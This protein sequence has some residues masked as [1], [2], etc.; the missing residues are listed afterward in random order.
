[1]TENAASPPVLLLHGWG[2]TG[3]RAWGA[4]PLRRRLLDAG[5]EVILIDLPGHGD[6]GGPTRPDGYA[7]L[8]GLT[9]ARIPAGRIDA[10]GFSLGGK[11]L[12]WLDA[13]HPGRF[14]RLV[15]GG[16]GDNILRPENGVMIADALAAGGVGYP[17]FVAEVVAEALASGNDQRALAAVI[18]R[19][20]L[21]PPPEVFQAIAA[22]VLLIRGDLDRIAGKAT[23]LDAAVPR[24][25]R[26]VLPG[27][28][29]LE[30]P[31]DSAFGALA[32]EFLLMPDQPAAEP[33][34]AQYGRP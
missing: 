1:M 28:G 17:P 12:L 33:R 34:D 20:G 19:P 10:V 23:V 32:A 3:Q 27:V 22:E 21:P 25:R 9:G 7:D 2:S 31:A 5:R 15:I 26:R 14:R 11:L 8:V 29:H 4:S 16:V 18:R 30:L 6:A 13:A 24:A